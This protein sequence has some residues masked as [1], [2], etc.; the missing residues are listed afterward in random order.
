M[1]VNSKIS[2]MNEI[3]N[4]VDASS[5]MDRPLAN[6]RIV[7]ANECQ[8][9]VFGEN[10]LGKRFDAINF[11]FCD[12]TE[13]KEILIDNLYALL[14][15]KYF[16]HPSEEI[17]KKIQDIVANFTMNLKTTLKKVSFDIDADC[18]IVSYLPDYCMAFR[19]GVWD[20]LNNKWFL[21]YDITYIEGLKN[22]IYQYNPYYIIN[23]YINIDFEPLPITLED[24]TLEEFIDL[25]KELSKDKHNYCFELLYNMSH[26]A[27]DKYDYN[28]FLHLCEILGFLSQVSFNQNFVIFTGIGGN[29][30]NSL[31]DGCFTYKVIP[32]PTSNSM[33]T[34][35]N[36]K[37]ITGTLLNRFHNIYLEIGDKTKE[38]DSEKLKNITGSPYQTIEIKGEPKFNSILNV[39]NIWSSN[40]QDSLKFKDTSQGFRRRINIYEI[41]YSWDPKKRFLRKGDYYDTTFS[42]DLREIKADLMNVTMFVYFA[43]YGLKEAT[44]N[45]TDNFEFSFNDWNLQYTDVDISL[46]E[47]LE[48]LR[49]Y[50]IID[51]LQNNYSEDYKYLFYTLNKKLLYSI[52]DIKDL[53][54][55]SFKDFVF[56]FLGDIEATTNYFSENDVYLNLKLLQK[57]IGESSSFTSKLKKIYNIKVNNTIYNNQPY[58]KIRILNDK[59]LFI[60]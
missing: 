30:K 41:F 28:K 2:S 11:K 40:S 33:D 13:A 19:N 54:Y 42:Q 39:K 20:F 14:R 34:Y 47:K 57:V 53:G 27:N 12:K 1:K 29:G 16:P 45:F 35:E 46:K 37:F 25:S 31:F 51:Y 50:N 32:T 59:V 18:D 49:L 6:W 43:M 60:D 48:K 23:W 44:K 38:F 8:V 5:L 7:L 56:G 26:D 4:A 55:N 10:Y 58:V 21:K 52:K 22:K 24:T 15:F 36:D 3:A 17:D 9:F